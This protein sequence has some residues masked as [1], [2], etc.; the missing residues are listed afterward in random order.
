MAGWRLRENHLALCH[1]RRI[2]ERPMA[3]YVSYFP[4]YRRP[5]CCH[6][7]AKIAAPGAWPKSGH[8]EMRV[9]RRAVLCARNAFRASKCC[10]AFTSGNEKIE[11]EVVLSCRRRGMFVASRKADLKGLATP[12]CARLIGNFAGRRQA[13]MRTFAILSC[14]LVIANPA[15]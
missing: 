12:F 2:D 3:I 6:R 13:I 5:H 11:V 1:R 10:S 9:S 8:Q 14:M 15:T 4:A 7:G